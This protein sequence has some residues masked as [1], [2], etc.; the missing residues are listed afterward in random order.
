MYVYYKE[1]VEIALGEVKGVL[2]RYKKL[3]WLRVGVSTGSWEVAEILGGKI[4]SLIEEERGKSLEK[5]VES[6]AEKD[7]TLACSRSAHLSPSPL[8][9]L[10]SIGQQAGLRD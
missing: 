9:R 10:A 3:R 6:R 8:H 4:E 1:S 7:L 5:R 2:Q